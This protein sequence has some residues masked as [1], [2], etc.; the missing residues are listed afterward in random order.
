MKTLVL[1]LI[2][3]NALSLM[4]CMKVKSSTTGLPNTPKGDDLD[5]HYGTLPAGDKYGPKAN[6]K[7]L[8]LKR[9]GHKDGEPISP[10]ENFNDVI[11]PKFIKSGDLSNTSADA[12]QI[13][14]APLATAKVDIH[15]DLVHDSIV[16][17]PVLIGTEVERVNV[18]TLDRETGNVVVEKTTTKKPVLAVLHT[19]REITTPIT[20]SVDLN[21]GRI[22]KN[23]SE[24]KLVGLE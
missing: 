20:T 10:I 21:T 4:F 23:K 15:T 11:V 14:D 9:A 5:N 12:T 18:S 3:N 16:S 17:T 22:I 24:K 19:A 7:G 13:I 6:L 1:F 2:L 8:N